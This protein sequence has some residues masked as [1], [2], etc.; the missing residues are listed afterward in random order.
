MTTRQ[1]KRRPWSIAR[2]VRQSAKS[3]SLA[4]APGISSRRMP[5]RRSRALR[6]GLDLGM[7]HIDTAEMYGSGAAERLV[8]EAIAGR[9]DEVFLVSKVLPHN[10]SRNGTIAACERSLKRLEDR[11][12][13]LLSSPLARVASS[14][15]HGRRLR[16]AARRRQDPV[17]GRQ[18]FRRG[19]SR[20]VEPGRRGGQTR[21]QSGALS[22]AR[23]RD[24][25]CCDPVVRRERRRGR[26][27]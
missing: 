8:G 6:R 13:R 25:A 2:S 14:R 11:P 15:R 9:R 7:T 10:A 12:P 23:A 19:R 24:R 27:L 4:R 3:Q 26:R 1:A 17:V 22:F 18:Q 21:L 5:R 16:A 20:R